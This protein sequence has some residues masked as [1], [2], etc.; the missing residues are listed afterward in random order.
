MRFGKEQLYEGLGP[1]LILMDSFTPRE[2][3]PMGRQIVL[4][5]ILKLR[6]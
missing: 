2:S 5:E 4:L 1:D 3:A 6:L